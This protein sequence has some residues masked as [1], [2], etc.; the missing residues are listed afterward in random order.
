MATVRRIYAQ[1]MMPLTPAAE[2]RMRKF[3]AENQQDKHGRHH[4]APDNFGLDTQDLAQRFK[5]YSDYFG[6]PSEL[7]AQR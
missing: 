7:P 4:Y 6:V 3:L 5:A 1:F 2:R